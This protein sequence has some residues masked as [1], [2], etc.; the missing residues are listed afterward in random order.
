MSSFFMKYLY[1]LFDSQSQLNYYSAI[2]EGQAID[3]LGS[4]F[5]QKK[6]VECQMPQPEF[7]K[8]VFQKIALQFRSSS[9]IQDKGHVWMMLQDTGWDFLCYWTLDHLENGI[10]LLVT[11]GKQDNLLSSHNRSNPH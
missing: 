6:K 9:L 10:C 7:R 3:L 1:L 8:I 4:D 5:S 11:I 2:K